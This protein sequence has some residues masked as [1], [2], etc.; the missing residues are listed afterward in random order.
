[1]KKSKWSKWWLDY[2]DWNKDKKTNW[3]EYFIPF[4]ILVLI[5]ILAEI[6]AQ[7]IINL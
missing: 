1:M 2:F 5:E 6:I 3:W 7:I 4:I